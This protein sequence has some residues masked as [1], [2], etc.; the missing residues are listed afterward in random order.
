[1]KILLLV[2]SIFFFNDAF[3]QAEKNAILTNFDSIV[4]YT[5]STIESAYTLKRG[6]AHGYAIEFDS[7]GRPYAIGK[8]SKGSKDGNW[9]L[10]D[11]WADFYENGKNVG[12]VYPGCGTGI[13]IAK[14]EFA[15][16]YQKLANEKP[17]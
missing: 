14:E 1:M 11:G 16:L 15:I 10:R 7:L 3:A 13:R 17:R 5:D 6:K 2:F 12:S 4:Y 8:Y 9:K